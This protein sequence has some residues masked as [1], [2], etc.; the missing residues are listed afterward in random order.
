M[1]IDPITLYLV[2]QSA[3]SF[4]AGQNKA[5]AQREEAEQKQR[6][7][8]ALATAEEKK[9][10]QDVQYIGRESVKIGKQQ[11]TMA[12]DRSVM[13]ASAGYSGQSLED[14]QT[15][16]HF[17]LQMDKEILKQ[18]ANNALQSSQEKAA[19]MRMA[20]DQ[21][22]NTGRVNQEMTWLDTAQSIASRWIPKG[23]Q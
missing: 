5:D 12:A 6:Y 19:Q 7:Y 14:V 23:G 13:A 17:N 4:F 21:A 1:S 8:N 11:K 20:G 10:Y 18:A 15:S 16:E 2:A 9:G 22:I 3:L